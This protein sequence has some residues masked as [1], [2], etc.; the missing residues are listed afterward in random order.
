MRSRV[1]V[2]LKF[3][4]DGVIAAGYAFHPMPYWPPGHG[5]AA[6]PAPHP[7]RV[8]PYGAL[9]PAERRWWREFESAYARG[10]QAR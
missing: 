4:L 7:E 10:D 6:P 5:P 9:S 1:R 3:L 2:V 8:V